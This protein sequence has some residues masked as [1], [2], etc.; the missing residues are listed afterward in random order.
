MARAVGDTRWTG[1][2]FLR[3]QRADLPLM[4]PMHCAVRVYHATRHDLDDDDPRWRDMRHCDF[5]TDRWRRRLG[6]ADPSNRP[7]DVACGEEIYFPLD[8]YTLVTSPL[9]PRLLLRLLS[10][11]N[12]ERLEKLVR[13]LG[14]A[15]LLA[16]V[17]FATLKWLLAAAALLLAACCCC[18]CCR[19]LCVRRRGKVEARVMNA[20]ERELLVGTDGILHE[21]F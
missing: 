1:V 7:Y 10:L 17:P 3:A 16:W 12:D 18:C 5:R 9:H 11:A 19:R 8:V 14:G 20:I 13:I 21:R 4:Y 15:R 2:A 6:G